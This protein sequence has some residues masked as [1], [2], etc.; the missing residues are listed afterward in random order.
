[1]AISPEHDEYGVPIFLYEEIRLRLSKPGLL[2]PARLVPEL[3]G[4]I[5]RLGPHHI[6]HFIVT[7]H[8]REAAERLLL[9]LERHW[10]AYYV[11]IERLIRAARRENNE[12]LLSDFGQS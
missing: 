5:L 4:V 6:A 3:D 7:T 1:M 10:P 12:E 9:Y 11:L 2:K 8:D